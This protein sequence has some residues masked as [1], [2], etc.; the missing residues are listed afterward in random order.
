MDRAPW[1]VES[2][3]ACNNPSR[4]V[5]RYTLTESIAVSTS[6]K[7]NAEKMR[8]ASGRRLIKGRNNNSLP[9][10]PNTRGVHAKTLSARLKLRGKE[11]WKE[12]KLWLGCNV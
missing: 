5:G 2:S 6:G 10:F 1:P 4:K 8:D 3:K 11:E 12:G 7:R 9:V